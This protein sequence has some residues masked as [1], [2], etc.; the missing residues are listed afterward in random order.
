MTGYGFSAGGGSLLEE[1]IHCPY[2]GEP[3]TVL[4]DG[5]VAQQKYTEDCQVCC[6]PMIMTVHVDANDACHL[7]V[8]RE[9]DT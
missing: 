1:R 4:V 5:S 2:C 9:D 7:Q 6:R 3:F 8:S